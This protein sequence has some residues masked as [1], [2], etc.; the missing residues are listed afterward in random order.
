MLRGAHDRA[1]LRVR[2][3]TEPPERDSGRR[4][5]VGR[6]WASELAVVSDCE[7]D[8]RHAEPFPC[9]GC[10]AFFQPAG[11]VIGPGDDK[12]LVGCERTQGVFDGFHRVGVADASLDIVG[13]RGI[14]GLVSEP[15]CLRAGVI[16]GV[17]QPAEPRDLRR[18]RNNRIASSRSGSVNGRT[19]F[20]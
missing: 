17:R 20:A 7:M 13:W 9:G 3:G 16:L 8:E 1:S 10:A 6:R 18:R 12:D 14:S 4:T 19:L 5:D 11:L 2:E 15:G